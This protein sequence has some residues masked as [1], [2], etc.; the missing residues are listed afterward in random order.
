[1]FCNALNSLNLISGHLINY[2]AN[3]VIIA[4][5]PRSFRRPF[6]LPSCVQFEMFARSFWSDDDGHRQPFVQTQNANAILFFSSLF[7]L[8]S[9]FRLFVNLSSLF[10]FGLRVKSTHMHMKEIIMR[11]T[12]SSI[13]KIV[14]THMYYILSPSYGRPTLFR[15]C[16]VARHKVDNRVGNKKQT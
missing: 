1:M 3:H 9:P 7:F 10:H 15:F 2:N 14:A 11:Q 8:C 5:V 16:F 13:R 4:Y 12:Y 6:V